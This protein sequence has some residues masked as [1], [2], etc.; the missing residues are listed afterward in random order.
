MQADG[1]STTDKR[2]REDHAFA[3]KLGKRLPPNEAERAEIDKA[4]KRTKA[5][6]PRIAMR[7]EDRETGARALTFAFD[8]LG[9]AQRERRGRTVRVENKS[10]S[11]QD[12]KAVTVQERLLAA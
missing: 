3:D 9:L 7:I 11:K 6:A 1:A 10:A 8:I 4:R 12:T 2:D 5:R